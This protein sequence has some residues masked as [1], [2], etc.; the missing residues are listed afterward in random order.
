MA[1][2]FVR[3]YIHGVPGGNANHLNTTDG[4]R[5]NGLFGRL[6][7]NVR[8]ASTADGTPHMTMVVGVLMAGTDHLVLYLRLSGGGNPHAST[9][10]SL[11]MFL[12]SKRAESNRLGGT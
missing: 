9:P 11:N 8:L 5:L 12:V 7:V 3:Q 10:P 4:K 1:T 6:G 2:L